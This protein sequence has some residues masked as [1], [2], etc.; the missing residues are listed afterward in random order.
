VRNIITVIAL[1]RRS[2]AASADPQHA[3][4]VRKYRNQRIILLSH[5]CSQFSWVGCWPPTA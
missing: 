3:S 4:Y 1:G 5:A 2:V